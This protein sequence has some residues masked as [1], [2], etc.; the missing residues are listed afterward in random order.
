MTMQPLPGGLL[1]LT[2][3]YN[4]Y[5]LV[6]FLLYGFFHHDALPI[7]SHVQKPFYARGVGRV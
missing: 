4:S 5:Y 2:D 3:L 6:L 7:L 1:S